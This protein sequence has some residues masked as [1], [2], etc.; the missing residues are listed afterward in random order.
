M[1][2]EAVIFD[3]DGTL[4]D[5][6]EY[7]SQAYEHTLRQHNLPPR[8]RAEIASQVGKKLE[9]CYAFLAPGA[10]QQALIAAHRAFQ[11]EN[12]QL[13]Q[14]F[15]FCNNVLEQ[16]I[17]EGTNVA[18]FSG[19]KNIVPSLETAGIDT[20]LFTAIVDGSHV[21]KGKPDPEGVYMVLGKLGV[22]AAHAVMV[23][24]AAVDIL[25]GRNAG[26]GATIGVTHGFGTL[27]ELESS[28]PDYILSSLVD[29]PAT[30]NKIEQTIDGP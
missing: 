16:L 1:R 17:S 22:K 18:L 19:R 2:V 9:D 26:L 21:E 7:I 15:D 24:D 20:G 25:A 12:L 14:P 5:T 28:E 8:T 10:E 11:A 23:G 30:I 6:S 27:E 3:V 4:V 13:I 29:L